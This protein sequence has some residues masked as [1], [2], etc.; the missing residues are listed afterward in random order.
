M[1]ATTYR[2][3]FFIL[4]LAVTLCTVS[5]SNDSSSWYPSGEATIVSSYEIPDGG[6]AIVLKIV[7]TGQSTISSYTISLMATTDVRTYYKTV[8]ENFVILPGKSVYV[9]VEIAYESDTEA[10]TTDGL[11][12]M[13]EYYQ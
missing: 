3:A 13:D 5:C 8:S 9:N 10:L 4:T 2:T 12:I 7:N 11:S 6:R 1:R